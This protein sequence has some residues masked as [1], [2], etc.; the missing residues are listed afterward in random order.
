VESDPAAAKHRTTVERKSEREVVV[1]RTFNAPA[2]VLFEAW[3]KPELL[4]RWWMPKSLGCSFDSCEIDARPGGSYRFTFSHPAA[5][6]PV[7][8]V[9]RYLEVEPPSRLSWT[10]EDGHDGHDGQVTTVTFEQRGAQTLVVVHDA[11]PSKEECDAS[12]FTDGFPESFEQ[13]EALL[14]TDLG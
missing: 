1:R 12:G 9:G 2:H 7:A 4:M 11:Y 6:E 10:N 3:I 13:L 8:F 5:E 14:V